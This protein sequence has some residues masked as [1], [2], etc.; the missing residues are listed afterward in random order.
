MSTN[1]VN[2]FDPTAIKD[3]VTRIHTGEHQ[4]V[5]PNHCRS[6]DGTINPIQ[7]CG[8]AL[9]AVASE[10]DP[11]EISFAGNL[12]KY[13]WLTIKQ[14]KWAKD[15]VKKYL[16]RQVFFVGDFIQSEPAKAN[17]C[18]QPKSQPTPPQKEEPDQ[19]G[20]MDGRDLHPST[21]LQDDILSGAAAIAACLQIPV[22]DFYNFYKR[23]KLPHFKTGRTICARKSVIKNWIE[24]QERKSAA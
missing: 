18:G 3:L 19:S 10:M 17:D 23:Q 20:Q 16:N 21:E 8:Y 5:L 13:H 4:I 22:K 24:S 12:T 7:A 9:I 15:L 11:H 6:Y 1:I 2:A 14:K